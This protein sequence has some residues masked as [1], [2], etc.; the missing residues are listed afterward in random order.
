MPD[1]DNA[2]FD[3]LRERYDAET[4]MPPEG[5]EVPEQYEYIRYKAF[6]FLTVGP[7]EHR[8]FD[9]LDQPPESWPDTVL[10]LVRLGCRQLLEWRGLMPDW[11][12]DGVGIGGFYSLLRLFHFGPSLQSALITEEDPDFICDRM[13]MRHFVTGEV[14][15]LFNRVPAPGTEHRA[16]EGCPFCG[17]ALRTPSARQCR[18]CGTDW[19][20]PANVRSLK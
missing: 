2:Y 3:A 1:Y 5:L 10:D 9:A 17:A 20:D 19:H 8:K 4:S 7:D 13:E 14:V 15:I 18:A 16:E 12:F 6:V 11:P